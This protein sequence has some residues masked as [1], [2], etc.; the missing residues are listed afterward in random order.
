MLFKLLRDILNIAFKL[1]IEKGSYEK[2]QS[3]K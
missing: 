1:F 2:Y 3:E